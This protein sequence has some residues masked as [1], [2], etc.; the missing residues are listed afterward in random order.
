MEDINQR[1]E[2]FHCGELAFP[3]P[4]VGKLYS[5]DSFGM[6]GLFEQI[7]ILLFALIHE[8]C[9]FAVVLELFLDA[10]IIEPFILIFLKLLV[11]LKFH[12][13]NFLW[14]KFKDFNLSVLNWL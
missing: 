12:P 14:L 4:V 10:L 8:L 6:K 1:L 5:D 3:D 13:F 11:K 7:E 2:S 9:L